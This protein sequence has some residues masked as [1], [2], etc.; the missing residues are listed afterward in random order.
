MHTVL[1][2]A[3][4]VGK[5]IFSLFGVG[6]VVTLSQLL[7]LSDKDS[8]C[9]IVENLPARSWG[10]RAIFTLHQKESFEVLIVHRINQRLLQGFIDSKKKNW[11]QQRNV[12]GFF[13]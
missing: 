11:P 12:P 3:T 6:L 8:R 4:I 7:D 2:C 13:P 9:A 10:R 5:D 1:E